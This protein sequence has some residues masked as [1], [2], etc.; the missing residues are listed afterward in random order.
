MN[1][2]WVDIAATSGGKYGAYLSLPPAGKGPGIVLFQEIFGVNRHI[3][4]VADQYA[5]DG[6]VVLAPDLFWREAPRVELGY[7]GAD[8]DRALQLMKGADPK[9]LAEDIKTSVAAL[10]AR[11]ELA[12]KVGAIGYCMGGRLAYLA[13]ATAGVDAAVCYYGGGIQ[14]QLDRA[15][16]IK[17]P[18]QFHYGAKDTAIPVEAVEKV[19][20]A[21][22]G[23]K[24][25][26]WI[27]PDAGHGFNCW[28]RA[29]YHAPSAALA[30]GRTL[31]FLAPTLF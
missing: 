19:K 30:H 17:C 12:G 9:L 22:V 3:R 14:D 15:T 4:A 7:E 1:S 11:P 16:S 31:V 27:Y 13:A 2:Q 28:D 21:F 6:F 8:R 25:Q 20:A 29:S 5:L 23:K 26:F 18:I 10:R 24:A